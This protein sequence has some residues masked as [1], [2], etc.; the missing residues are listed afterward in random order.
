MAHGKDS[1]SSYEN[2]NAR[3]APNRHAKGD[4]KYKEVISKD[5]NGQ[6]GKNLPF[7]FIKPPKSWQPK[8]DIFYVCDFCFEVRMVNKNTV[9]RVCSGCQKFSKVHT[10]N[11]FSDVDSLNSYLALLNP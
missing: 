2:S 9:G 8:R 6:G 5:N 7:T 4:K 3:V 10:D 11:S 1:G